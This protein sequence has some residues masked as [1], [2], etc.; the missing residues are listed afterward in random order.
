MICLFTSSPPS[1]D[2]NNNGV[3]F[4]IN[5]RFI[6]LPSLI[7]YANGKFVHDVGGD[8]DPDEFDGVDSL[9][10]DGENDYGFDEDDEEDEEEEEEEGEEE[11]EETNKNKQKTTE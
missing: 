7:T 9:D 10:G 8:F 5:S 3:S 2:N 4:F 11:E 1:T 6:S